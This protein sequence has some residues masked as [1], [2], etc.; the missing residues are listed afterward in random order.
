MLDDETS[1]LAAMQVGARGYLLK[2]AEQH[3][4]LAAIRTVATKPEILPAMS[5]A[6][7]AQAGLFSWDRAARE[8]LDV[9][10]AALGGRP[11]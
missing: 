4:V 1:V 2:D 7:I 5:A 9:F 11:A 3:E 8:T 10:W 6:G